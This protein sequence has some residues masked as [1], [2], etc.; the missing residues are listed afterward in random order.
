MNEGLPR[1]SR[2]ITR[3]RRAR[4]GSPGL[5]DRLA[6]WA[7]LLALV[8]MGMAAATAEAVGG[9]I[10]RDGSGGTTSAADETASFGSRVLRVGMAGSDVKVLNGII[11]SKPYAGQVR[12]SKVFEDPTAAAVEQFQRRW[13]LSPTGVVNRSTARDLT[14]SMRVTLATW[15]GPGLYGSHTACGQVLGPRTI[16]VAHRTLPCGTKVTFAYHGRY[17]VAPVIDRGPYADGRDF[18]LTWATREALRF[19]DVDRIRFAVAR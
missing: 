7:L 3:V 4:G 10:G 1:S 18:D 9:G 6:L 11:R 15:Y 17:V 12:I 13:D 2:D 14:S 16:G 19:A 5:P 8:L